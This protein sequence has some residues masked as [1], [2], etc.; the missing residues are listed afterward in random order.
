MFILNQIAVLLA[1]S[2]FQGI[3]VSVHWEISLI[4]TNPRPELFSCI[5]L[6]CTSKGPMA[7]EGMA[8][9]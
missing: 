3:Q 4:L 1:T 7:L 6:L 2:V 5:T 9:C 8:F